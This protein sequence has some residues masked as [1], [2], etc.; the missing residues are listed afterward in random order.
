VYLCVHCCYKAEHHLFNSI[1]NNLFGSV[2]I[3]RFVLCG[4]AEGV[5][6]VFIEKAIFIDKV[7]GIKV[8]GF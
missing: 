1:A 5:I 4:I 6:F 7:V 2:I 3:S 8:H